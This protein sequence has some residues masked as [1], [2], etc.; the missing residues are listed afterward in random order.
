MDFLRIK[1]CL[2]YRA[3]VGE[4]GQ[5][6]NSAQSLLL[7]EPIARFPGRGEVGKASS[8]SLPK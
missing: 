8:R 6:W 2:Y 3:R 4:S 5:G 7:A 1:H